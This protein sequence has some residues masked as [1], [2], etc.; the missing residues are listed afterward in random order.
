MSDGNIFYSQVDLNLQAELDARGKAGRFDRSNASLNYML[1]KVANVEIIAMKNQKHVD[2][3]NDDD[4]NI[5]HR[6]GGKSVRSGQYLP[7]GNNGFLTERVTKVTDPQ[8]PSGSANVINS[9]YRIAPFITS[10]EMKF[11]DHSAGPSGYVNEVT[12]NIVIPNPDRDL[13]FMESVYARPGRAVTMIIHCNS[14]SRS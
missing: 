14:K 10:A 7:T 1:E 8:L 6:L 9:S 11:A 12:V 13:D 4:K 3:T 2:L 5:L